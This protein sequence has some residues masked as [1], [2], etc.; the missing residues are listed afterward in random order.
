M[1]L[2]HCR[3]YTVCT[4]IVKHKGDKSVSPQK[5]RHI[6]KIKLQ[7]QLHF[8]SSSG[9]WRL[10]SAWQ[11]NV[12]II[13]HHILKSGPV[14]CIVLHFHLQMSQFI[15]PL[16]LSGSRSRTHNLQEKL[17]KCK[18]L[19]FF[20]RCC[21]IFLLKHF[22]ICREVKSCWVILIVQVKLWIMRFITRSNNRAPIALCAL[23]SPSI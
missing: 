7:F 15:H 20:F 3:Q 5:K 14:C 19:F 22:Q 10:N 6:S 16:W 1:Y 21:Q 18:T 2:F 11:V 23:P 12:W 17:N 9:M 8:F 4:G 13:W